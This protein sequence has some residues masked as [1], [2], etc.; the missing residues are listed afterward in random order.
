MPD[1]KGHVTAAELQKQ[2]A[3]LD[4]LI[5]EAE[6]LREKI[7]QELNAIRRAGR[8]DHA[9]QPLPDRRRIRGRLK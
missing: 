2:R 1:E 6:R 5:A 7:T 3:E 4:A 9:G 8:V